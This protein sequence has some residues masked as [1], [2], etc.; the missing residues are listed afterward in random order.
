MTRHTSQF[1]LASQVSSINKRIPIKNLESC[2]TLDIKLAKAIA[3]SL[4]TPYDSRDTFIWKI[5]KATRHK[6]DATKIALVT[7]AIDL[8][9]LDQIIAIDFTNIGREEF[10]KANPEF[11]S[12]VVS[13]AKY[14]L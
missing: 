8:I 2:E 9:N 5:Y 3:Y 7:Y 12:K 13:Q 1:L 11:L 6:L 4:M 10:K 14:L